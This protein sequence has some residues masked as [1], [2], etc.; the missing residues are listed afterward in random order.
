MLTPETT[1]KTSA[2]KNKTG[3]LTIR[4][5]QKVPFSGSFRLNRSVGIL[6]VQEEN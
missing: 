6:T 4:R 2:E 3:T 1:Q 5:N